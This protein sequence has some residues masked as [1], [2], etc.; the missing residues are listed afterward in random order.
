MKK[1]LFFLF[2]MVGCFIIPQ[3]TRAQ[4][5]TGT[6]NAVYTVALFRNN[7]ILVQDTCDLYIFESGSWFTGRNRKNMEQ[8]VYGRIANRTADQANINSTDLVGINKPFPFSFLKEYDTKSTIILEQIDD[9]LFAYKDKPERAWQITNEKD[10]L[11]NII[12]TKATC[13]ENDTKYTAWF[14]ADIPADDG[15][16][17][18]YGLPGLV[19]KYEDSKGWGA[20]L[21]EIHYNSQAKY[22][23][24]RNYTLTTAEKIRQAKKIGNKRIINNESDAKIKLRKIEK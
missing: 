15:P 2:V 3:K 23:I 22:T 9:Q 10:T 7:R 18:G 6:T 21:I 16:L 8:I 4:E 11:N 5:K 1:G 19:V 13:E 12:C 20:Y 14:S 24:P 17:K